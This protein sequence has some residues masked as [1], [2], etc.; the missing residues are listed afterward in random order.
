MKKEY[1]CYEQG[2]RNIV[3]TPDTRCKNHS[4]VDRNK[5]DAVICPRP[6]KEPEDLGLKREED[7]SLTF[8]ESSRPS[9]SEFNLSEKKN[10]GKTITSV[11]E[12]N[13]DY[14]RDSIKDGSE[15]NLSDERFGL[16]KNIPEAINNNY[17]FYPE[18]KVKEFIKK[19]KEHKCKDC[20]VI[21]IELKEFNKLAGRKLLI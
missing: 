19:I 16:G 1:Y 20:D 21:L 18:K 15:F 2:C 17:F 4:Q 7:S 8:A 9:G 5:G 13:E 10:H 12:Y 11:E 14:I 3:D 6:D